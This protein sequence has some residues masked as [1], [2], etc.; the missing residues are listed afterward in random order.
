MKNTR[1]LTLSIVAL[2][3]HPDICGV[4]EYLENLDLVPAQYGDLAFTF[5]S[6]EYADTFDAPIEW[7]KFKRSN[8]VV[9]DPDTGMSAYVAYS[10]SAN[11]IVA[12]ADVLSGTAEMPSPDEQT[13]S[14]RR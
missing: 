4:V 7:Y 2:K 1:K 6:E 9:V 8:C 13:I 3:D 14:T 10:K 11:T 5:P 12:L